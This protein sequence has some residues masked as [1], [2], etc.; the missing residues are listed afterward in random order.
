[1]IPAAAKSDSPPP[2]KHYSD[3]L[4]TTALEH[5]VG[6]T[7]TACTS[8]LPNP[9]GTHDIQQQHA[10]VTTGASRDT[11]SCFHGLAPKVQME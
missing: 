11:L 7:H 6:S 5:L 10:V 2:P 1:M 9:L 4:F 3:S 8:A